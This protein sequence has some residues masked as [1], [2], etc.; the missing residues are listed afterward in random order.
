MIFPDKKKAAAMILASIKPGGEISSGGE[1]KPEIASDQHDDSLRMIAED[2]LR[3]HG[4]KS[5]LGL[6]Q[7]MK[8][9]LAQASL[10]KEE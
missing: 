6:A 1:K 10:K 3:A 2:M 4:E 7:S 8:A 5:A 9:F